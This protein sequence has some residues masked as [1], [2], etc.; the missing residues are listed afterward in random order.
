MVPFRQVLGLRFSNG[1]S[2]QTEALVPGRMS[3][4]GDDLQLCSMLYR[5]YR[6]IVVLKAVRPVERMGR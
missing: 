2:G 6:P 1:G 3:G 4:K 5:R